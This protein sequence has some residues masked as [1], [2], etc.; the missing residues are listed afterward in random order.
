[1]NV[2]A[3]NNH[4]RQLVTVGKAQVI[5]ITCSVL[6]KCPSKSMTVSQHAQH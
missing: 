1:M 3:K 2:V 5:L 6:F 4:S